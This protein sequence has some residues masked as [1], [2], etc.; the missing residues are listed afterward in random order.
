MFS[1]C[2]HKNS[3]EFQQQNSQPLTMLSNQPERNKPRENLF[4]KY[5][6]IRLAKMELKD[7]NK[8]HNQ[9]YRA[10]T[11]VNRTMYP[12]QNGQCQLKNKVRRFVTLA[13][14]PQSARIVIKKTSNVKRKQSENWSDLNQWN[15]SDETIQS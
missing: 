3:F 10:K 9:T 5:M 4:Q 11:N 14:F 15:F 12:I 8:C 13:E 7:L 2:L 6:K 1:L